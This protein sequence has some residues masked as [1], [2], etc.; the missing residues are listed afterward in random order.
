MRK[1]LLLGFVPFL[2]SGCTKSKL[3]YSNFD[4]HHITWNEIF[5]IESNAYDVYFYSTS[6]MHCHSI[7]DEVLRFANKHDEN[8]F[9]VKE[10]AQYVFGRDV[11]NT[12]GITR[13][14][15]FYVAG[16]P[17]LVH[18]SYGIVSSHLLGEKEIKNYIETF[19]F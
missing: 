13:I 10:S 12:I 19:P 15:D 16:V 9:F 6:C 14:E 8:F 11:E 5:T 2:L 3:D 1:F 17:T 7:K 4:N 18:I